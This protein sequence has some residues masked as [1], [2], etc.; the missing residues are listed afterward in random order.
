[1]LAKLGLSSAG[2][3]CGLNFLRCSR[4]GAGEGTPIHVLLRLVLDRSGG[5]G[6]A[7]R[8]LAQTPVSAS[9]CLTLAGDDG[10]VVAVEISPGGWRLVWPDSDGRLLHTNHFL[11]GPAEGADL[12]AL[13]APSTALRLWDLGRLAPGAPPE[14]ALRSHAGRPESVCRHEREEDPW[15][16]RRA[17]LASVLLD[18]SAHSMRVADG[19]PC[20]HS[21]KP[22]ALP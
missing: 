20:E 15:A 13:E 6:D 18:A 22:V 14:V 4:D 19:P 10:V 21:Y 12:E 1:M 2:V 9:A 17:T 3:A 11:A 8:L 7:L 16:E 5:V